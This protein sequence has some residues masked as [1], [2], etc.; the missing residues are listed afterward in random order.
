MIT[1]CQSRAARGFLQ[2]SPRDLAEHAGIAV[3]SVER[4]ESGRYHPNVETG[5]AVRAAFERVGVQFIGETELFEAA[6]WVKKR[7][8]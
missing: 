5:A 1:A 3:Q 8:P 4:F 6:P 2:W 7:L